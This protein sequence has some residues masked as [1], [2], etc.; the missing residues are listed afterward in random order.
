MAEAAPAMRAV[1]ERLAAQ[2]AGLPSRYG[3][4]FPE[5]RAVLLREREPWLA[6]GPAC[7]HE[8][9]SVSY[10]G[11]TVALRVYHPEAPAGARALRGAEAAA[12]KLT[13]IQ[14]AAASSRRVLV[15]LHGGGWC[16]GS[17]A[18]HDNIVRRLAVGLGCTAWSID[19]ALAPEAP[20]PHGLDDAVAAIRAA[21]HEHPGAALVV[22]GDSAGAN[23]A[24]DAALR[25]REPGDVAIEA[26]LL[27]Y[28]V[29]T[30]ALDDASM[31][32]HG[33]GRWGLSRQAH[34]RYLDAYRGSAPPAFALDPRIDVHGLPP[35]R[36]TIAELD[37]LRDQSHALAAKL[38]GA[39]VAVAVDEV[40]GVI[41]GFLSY[42][43]QLPQAGAALD[44]AWAW[45]RAGVPAPDPAASPA[46]DA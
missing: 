3:L 15:Y 40:P 26:L 32:A 4:P 25:L 11:R 7:A 36:L 8:A 34:E 22:A 30:D 28:G 19:Y 12:S 6:D 39:G 14:T 27:F 42:G 17:P 9:R 38:R 18:T 5:A 44:A 31:T 45:V 13:P 37:I 21:A 24:L 20:Y 2:R 46:A 10:G 23:L 29:Y 35:T 43:L 41:H 33:D 1:L 16:V